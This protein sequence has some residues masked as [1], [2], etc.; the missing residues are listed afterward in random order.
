M[1]IKTIDK[2]FS[3]LI[4]VLALLAFTKTT[5]AAE[6]HLVINEVYYDTTGTDASE[7]WIE[8]YN[9]TESDIELLD[10]QVNYSSHKIVIGSGQVI[11]SKKFAI[12]ARDSVNFKNIYGFEALNVSDFNFDLPNSGGYLILKDNNGDDIDAVFWEKND[13]ND[14]KYSVGVATGHS[15]EREPLG[16]DT[17]DCSKDFVDRKI[18]SPGE[19]FID[20]EEK[21]GDNPVNINDARELENGKKVT[22]E[23]TVTVL[24]GTL[25]PQYFYIQ[26][27]TGGIQIYCYGKIFPS[28]QI[29]DRI[30]VVGEL[31]EINNERRIKYT[32]LEN[33]VTLFHTNPIIP[34]EVNISNIGEEKEG[35]LIKTM[36]VVTKTSGNTFYI[37]DGNKEIQVSIKATTG[38]DKPKMKKGD[39]VE[40]SGIVSQ[41]KDSY[42]IL[43]IDQDDV[44]ILKHKEALPRAGCEEFIYLLIS[45]ISALLWNIFLAVKRKL[46]RLQKE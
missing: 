13:I 11:L 21:D 45:G 40:V 37:S 18:P 20:E 16:I 28:L 17:D 5:K 27:E 33:I 3:C 8:L 34:E 44:I 41:Y 9:P 26:D 36:G 4:A 24:P 43:P 22:V 7:E 25:S 39:T 12:I 23:G 46:W 30:S 38:I 10:Y 15:I 42:R 14:M 35:A 31:S 1:K 6:E 19:E 29:G 32:G 2:L